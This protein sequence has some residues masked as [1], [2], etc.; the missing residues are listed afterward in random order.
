MRALP[1]IIGI[2]V[3]LTLVCSPALA[4]GKSDLIASHK[5]QSIPTKPIINFTNPPATL[6]IPGPTTVPT[7]IPTGTGTLTIYRIGYLV[8]SGETWREIDHPKDVWGA[9]VYL[10]GTLKGYT[11][12]TITGIPI[13]SHQVKV[14]SSPHFQYRDYVAAVTVLEGEETIVEVYII[15]GAG[16]PI[17]TNAKGDIAAAHGSELPPCK[18]CKPVLEG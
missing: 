5:G 12:L 14:I 11:P 10:D 1:V 4:I 15:G 8:V 17:P 3:I 7:Q 13:G 9:K 16:T 6:P 18:L 2:V